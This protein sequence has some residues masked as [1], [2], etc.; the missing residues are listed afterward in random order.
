MKNH[1]WDFLNIIKER[2]KGQSTFSAI[3]KFLKVRMPNSKSK[4]ENSKLFCLLL[5]SES[6]RMIKSIIQNIC[7]MA[8]L[9]KKKSQIHNILKPLHA[10]RR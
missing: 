10:L 9:K 6:T 5:V 2:L 4:E 3:A 7:Q 1:D 8:G